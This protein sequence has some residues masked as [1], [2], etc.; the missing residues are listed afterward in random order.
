[1]IA[2]LF[3]NLAAN[4]T[5][6][7]IQYKVDRDDNVPANP[8]PLSTSLYRIWAFVMLAIRS[9]NNLAITDR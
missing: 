9:E 5:E 2:K 1:M 6:A 7:Q 3:S 4:I 8:L